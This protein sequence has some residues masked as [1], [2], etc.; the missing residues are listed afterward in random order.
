MDIKE[1]VARYR[2]KYLDMDNVVGIGIGKKDKA[3]VIVIMVSDKNNLQ[4]PQKI[5]EYDVD[6]REVG[7]FRV[8]Q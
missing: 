2:K 3:E 1:V 8:N 6:I 4:I 5:E 7:V